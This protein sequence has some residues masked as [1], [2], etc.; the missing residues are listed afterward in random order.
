M[1]P[2]VQIPAPLP[3][4]RSVNIWLLRGTPLTLI[5]AGPRSGMR[6]YR[7]QSGALNKFDRALRSDKSPLKTLARL[8]R[9]RSEGIHTASCGF[10]DCFVALALTSQPCNIRLAACLAM[11]PI[12]RDENSA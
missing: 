1:E 11:T 9:E 5:D 8:Y 10:L 3:H 7:A 6:R 12:D 2:I 4:I